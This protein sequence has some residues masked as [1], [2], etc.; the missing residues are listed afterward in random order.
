MIRG[1]SGCISFF[2][3]ISLAKEFRPRNPFGQRVLTRFGEGKGSMKRLLLM[4][5]VSCAGLLPLLAQI[6]N[7]RVEGNLTDSSLAAV[8]GAKLTIV[9]NRT[10]VKADAESD[11]TG[12]FFFPV[13]QP[14]MYT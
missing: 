1:E 9:N 13:L 11:Q 8:P 14:G 7:A 5:L 10:Q 3:A 6:Q 2:G 12:F 4:S